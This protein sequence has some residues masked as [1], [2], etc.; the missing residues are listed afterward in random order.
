MEKSAEAFRT[1]SEVAEDLGLPQHVLRFW[2]TRFSQIKPLKRAGG[3][4]FYRPHDI[5]ILRAI[6]RLLYAEGYTIKGV[7]R[8][9][10]EQGARAVAAAG[11]PPEDGG[12][13]L[14]VAGAT[15]TSTALSEANRGAGAAWRD[16]EAQDP[17]DEIEPL[18]SDDRRP[19]YSNLASAAGAS[20]GDARPEMAWPSSLLIKDVAILRA[21]VAELEECE[22][23]L[24]MVRRP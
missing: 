22:R 4:R 8:L 2:E 7:Q 1:I 10:R 21:A 16:D 14:A 18:A 13:G 12:P 9:F 15:K 24:A 23:V 6:K 11:Q 3:R 17:N 19:A 20:D 5:E